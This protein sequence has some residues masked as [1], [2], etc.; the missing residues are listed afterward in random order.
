M[1]CCADCGNSIKNDQTYYRL[2]NSGSIFCT[3]N[4]VHQAY[5]GFYLNEHIAKGIQA[6]S[7]NK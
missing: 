2:N 7:R 3:K 4:C 6:F 1:N 5:K